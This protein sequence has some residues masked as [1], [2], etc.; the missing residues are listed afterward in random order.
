MHAQT[1]DEVQKQAQYPPE[2]HLCNENQMFLMIKN[3]YFYP[4]LIARASPERRGPSN[5]RERQVQVTSAMS[6]TGQKGG[7]N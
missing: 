3:N 1:W 4:K 6:V 7:V 2:R 5:V